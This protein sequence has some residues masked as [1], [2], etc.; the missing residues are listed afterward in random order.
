[1]NNPEISI[2][3]PV[4]NM[5]RYL[6]ECLESIKKQTFTNWECILVD[7]GSSDNSPAICEQYA[8]SDSRFK[9]IH[10]QNRGLSVARN[11]ALRTVS[12]EYIGFVD[13]D[14]WIEP[15]MF[16]LL[17]KLVTEHDADIAQ[18]GFRKKYKSHRHSTKH[19]TDNVKV[20]DGETAMREIGFN[21][22]PNYVW[23][24]LHRRGIITCDF[25]EGRNFEDIFVY[26]Q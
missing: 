13:A 21:R 1:M 16:E 11:T 22:L 4:Y 7:D 19:L 15:E 17:Y 3:V 26:S 24:K 23:N 6:E 2:I 18:V 10:Q 9:A 5:E 12:S 25:P 8:E 20:I 14:D